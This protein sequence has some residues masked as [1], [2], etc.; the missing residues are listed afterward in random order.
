M[1]VSINKRSVLSAYSESGRINSSLPV[2]FFVL[3]VPLICIVGS[4]TLPAISAPMLI[5]EAVA[6]VYLG[7]LITVWF[8]SQRNVVDTTLSF[9]RVTLLFSGMFILGT[10]SIF[11]ATNV[12]F[13]ITR[14]L[15]WYCAAIVFFF[16]LKVEQNEKNINTIFN[17]LVVAGTLVS[18]IGL[19]QYLF[20]FSA[21]MLTQNQPASTFGNKNMAGQVIVL[22]WPFALFFLFSKKTSTIEA[23]AYS[24]CIALMLSYVFVIH[25]AAVLLSCFLE[26][27]LISMVLIFDFSKRKKWFFW[28]SQKTFAAIFSTLLFFVI[29]NP[30]TIG[31]N[32]A[33]DRNGIASVFSASLSKVTSLG[34]GETAPRVMNYKDAIEMINEDPVFGSGLGSFFDKFRNGGANHRKMIGSR[35][36]HND[37][38]ELGVELGLSGLFILMAIVLSMCSCLLVILKYSE[39]ANRLGALLLTSAIAGGVL[40]AQFSFPFQLV[41]PLVIIA[42]LVAMLTKNAQQYLPLQSIKKFKVG[43]RFQRYS[44]L[45]SACVLTGTI[46]LNSQWIKDYNAISENFGNQSQLSPYIVNSKVLNPEVVMLLRYAAQVSYNTGWYP[47]GL[48][49]LS[50]LMEL[51]PNAPVIGILAVVLNKSLQN[52]EETEKWANVLVNSQPRDSLIGELS[53][54]EVYGNQGNAEGLT[55]IYNKLKGLPTYVFLKQPLVLDSVIALS[56][57][58]GDEAQTPLHYQKYIDLFPTTAKIETI[59]AAHYYKIEQYGRALPHMR[60]ALDMD[61]DI[62]DSARFK[63][64]LEEYSGSSIVEYQS[65]M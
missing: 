59:M 48:N 33:Y 62:L 60:K 56:V 31:I 45:V 2:L 13:H 3:V 53:L 19:V 27:L 11:W 8:W 35:Q 43:A 7:I 18:L 12:D 38:L 54:F 37:T 36:V 40:N 44:F 10:L 1:K 16:G 25:S 21:Q 61:P 29:C 49:F 22:L 46:I 30:T 28:N 24:I 41:A 50:P 26:I 65:E 32:P 23:W 15:M 57:V 39:G 51:L 14:W 47:Q 17:C 64:I 9:S 42:L 4:W 55:D 5:K 34:T 63:R 6:Q 52:N 20:S 58:L